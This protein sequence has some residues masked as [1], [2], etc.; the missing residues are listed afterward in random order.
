MA[1]PHMVTGSGGWKP[2]AVPS[3]GSLPGHGEAS[4]GSTTPPYPTY[5]ECGPG[6]PDGLVFQEKWQLWI[7]GGSP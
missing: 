1:W 2:P 5:Q 3:Q 7:W 4:W 6:L